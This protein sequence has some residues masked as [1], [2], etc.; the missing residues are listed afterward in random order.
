[1]RKWKDNENAAV[2]KFFKNVL[3]VFGTIGLIFL[4]LDILVLHRI[5]FQDVFNFGL[6]LFA[7][8]AGKYNGLY[9]IARKYADWKTRRKDNKCDYY[10]R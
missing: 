1:M 2:P 9:R 5:D 10:S 7:I 6:G 3:I 8:W 4:P